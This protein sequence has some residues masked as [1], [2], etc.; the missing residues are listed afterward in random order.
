MKRKQYSQE[1]K[2]ALVQSVLNK[3]QTA[4]EA[5]RGAKISEPM[6]YQW[7]RQYLERTGQMQTNGATKVEKVDLEINKNDEI[8]AIVYFL[9]DQL[10]KKLKSADKLRKAIE[11]LTSKDA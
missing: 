10:E 8:P 1:F 7:R 2:D 3:K 6:F 4:T 5:Y 9:Q 11:M